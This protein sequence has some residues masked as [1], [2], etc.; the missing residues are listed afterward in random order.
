MTMRYAA[1]ALPVLL[2]VSACSSKDDGT[3]G[4]TLS[5]DGKSEDGGNIVASADGKTGK[6]KIDMPGM[7]AEI[8]L[9]KI[10]LDAGSFDVDGASLYPESKLT[11]VNVAGDSKDGKDRGKVRVAFDA[12]ADKAVVTKWFA[13]NWAA[14]SGFTAAAHDDGV[15]GTTS[16]GDAFAITLQQ[17]P[18]GHTLGTLSVDEK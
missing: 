3:E 17:G 5:L 6:V 10:H 9:P 13:E 1:F 18:A 14:K 7:K 2:L 15:A 11:T 4:T 12:P 16:E 8:D